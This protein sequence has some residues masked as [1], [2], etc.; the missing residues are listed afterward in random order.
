M[1][2]IVVAVT[3]IVVAPP[4]GV[5]VARQVEEEAISAIEGEVVS[6]VEDGGEHHQ[7]TSYPSTLTAVLN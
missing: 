4:V 2:A 3:V 5:E 1:I 7:Y 6:A